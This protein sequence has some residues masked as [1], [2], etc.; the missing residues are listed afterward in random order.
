ML[1]DKINGFINRHTDINETFNNFIKKKQ[2]PISDIK[3]D[4]D[5]IDMK[6]KTPGQTIE[7][8]SE[9]PMDQSN[10]FD[11]MP[12]TG[13]HS[14]KYI[15]RFREKLLDSFEPSPSISPTLGSGTSIEPIKCAP[16]KDIVNPPKK[17]RSYKDRGKEEFI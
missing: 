1:L 2:K 10:Y 14:E 16:D 6:A 17:K 11:I 3:A 7:N 4:Q 13:L 5:V 12:T 8:P 15:N 9:R